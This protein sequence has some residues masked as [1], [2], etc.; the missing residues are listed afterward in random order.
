[1]EK[2]SSI[3]PREVQ[4]AIK[5]R[6]CRIAKNPASEKRFPVGP[7]SAKRLG[8]NPTEI[9][10]LPSSVTESFAG[11]GC[12]LA[13]GPVREGEIVLDLGS[14]AG[15]DAF[16]VARRV[17]PKGRVIGID[18]TSEMIRKAESNRLLLGIENVEFKEGQVENLPLEDVSIDLAMTNGVINLCLDKERVIQEIYRVLKPGGRFYGADIILEEGVDQATVERL[19]TWSD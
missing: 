17:G 16:L 18:M 15:M 13:L 11:V 7:E 9:D 14:G 8:Y 19:G 3:I 1:M 6:F 10:G 12:P 4:E 5:N 2:A